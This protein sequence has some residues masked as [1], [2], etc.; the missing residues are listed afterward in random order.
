MVAE[1]I[2]FFA[3]DPLILKTELDRANSRCLKHKDAK[4]AKISLELGSKGHSASG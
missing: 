1:A 2:L 3:K 4:H